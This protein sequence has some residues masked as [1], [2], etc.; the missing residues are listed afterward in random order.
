MVRLQQMSYILLAL[1]LFSVMQPSYADPPLPTP[2]GRVVWVQGTLKAI[3]PNKEERL[4]QKTT[5]NR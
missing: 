5:Q 3:M 1:L 4:L 2:V